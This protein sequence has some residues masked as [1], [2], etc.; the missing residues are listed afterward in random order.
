MRAWRGVAWRG[1]AWRGVAWRGVA[2]RG[3]A[4]RGVAWRGVAWRGVVRAFV[5]VCDCSCRRL[6]V[7]QNNL[8]IPDPRQHYSTD[9]S[10]HV[11]VA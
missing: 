9:M 11:V 10:F 2:W 6:P 7:H 1:V 4:W 3:V 5:R 8:M